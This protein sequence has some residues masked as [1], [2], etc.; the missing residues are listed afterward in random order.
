V[1]RSYV[2]AV[3]SVDGIPVIIPLMYEDDRIVEL[4]KS[5][6][7]IIFTGGEDFDPSYYNEPAIPNVNRIN[8]PRDVFDIKLLRLAVEHGI[9]VLGICRGV[10][11]I[12]VACGGSLYQD[13]AAQYPDRSIKHRQTQPK[14]EAS[15]AVIVEE[16]S[17]LASITGE[18]M[19]MV[20]SSHHQAIKKLADGFR[21][22]GVAPDKVIE[23]IEKVDSA[24]WI[25]GVQ[26]HPEVM[27]SNSPSMRSIFKGFM[28]EASRLKSGKQQQ[29]PVH[30]NI[31]DTSAPESDTVKA[32]EPAVADVIPADV[33]IPDKIETVSDEDKDK[34]DLRS[35]KERR[36]EEMK[37]LRENEKLHSDELKEKE[38]QEKADFNKWVQ[39]RKV[40]EKELAEKE[41]AARKE[42]AAKEKQQQ[43]EL[44]EKAAKDKKEQAQQKKLAAKEQR[45]KEKAAKKEAAAK[46][47]QRQKELKEQQEKEN[48]AKKEAGEKDKQYQ[49]EQKERAKTDK[50]E[51]KKMQK[52]KKAEEKKQKA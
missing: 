11:L 42:A 34:A 1:P 39:Q 31:P 32:P 36:R 14:E 37:R 10:Q 2:D 38:K 33:E 7:G 19:L 30:A 4:L 3:L 23:A 48:A 46:E 52:Q 24:H 20:N 47:E 6:D 21:V 8:A 16:G 50:R 27:I 41:N 43:K 40:E 18:R 22:T 29:P 45:E 51:L 9:P 35:P 25:V 28:D 15:H 5:L 17:V 13:L 49:R 44:K 12:N 26:F